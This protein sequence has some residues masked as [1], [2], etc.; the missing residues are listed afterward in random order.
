MST[1][2]AS[3]IEHIPVSVAKLKASLMRAF[4]Q[5]GEKNGHAYNGDHPIAQRMHKLFC[6]KEARAHFNA[7]YDSALEDLLV[8]A[9]VDSD[10]TDEGTT[11]T[12]CSAEEYSLI[13]TRQRSSESIDGKQLVNELKKSVGKEIT[14]ELIEQLTTKATKTRAGAKRFDIA[15]ERFDIVTDGG[16]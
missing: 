7:K 11:T 2:P 6:I 10:S 9:N 1:N 16:N 8:T 14:N 5:L 13:L 4:D 12:L 15:I 3:N